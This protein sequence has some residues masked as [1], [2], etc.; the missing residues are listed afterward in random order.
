MK[1]YQIKDKVPRMDTNVLVC[2]EPDNP[3]SCDVCSFIFNE[4]DD[5]YIWWRTDRSYNVEYTDYWAEISMP[6]PNHKSEK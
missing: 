1:W 6:K 4:N 2:F 5:R 3:F